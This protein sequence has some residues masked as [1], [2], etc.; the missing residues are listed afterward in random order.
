[1]AT[2]YTDTG[3]VFGVTYYY[4]LYT[5]DLAG[6]PAGTSVA[7]SA[8]VRT[9]DV[10]APTAL[11]SV[12]PRSTGVS[13]SPV[14][15]MTFS[16]PM[17]FG[18]TSTAITL[19]RLKDNL[20]RPL[21]QP[22]TVTVSSN[23]A[24]DVYTV[25]IAP[26]FLAGNSLYE[27]AIS[28]SAADVFGKT[29]TSSST[30]RFTTYLDHTVSNVVADGIGGAVVELS[31]GALAVDGYLDATAVSPSAVAAAT[32][33]LSG[34]TGDAFRSPLSSSVVDLQVRDVSGTLQPGT[35]SA[36]VSVT[37]PYADVDGDGIVDG[38]NPPAKAS[39]LGVYWLNARDDL[40]VRLPSSRDAAARQVSARSSHFTT[41]A[42]IPQADTD[43]SAAHPYPVP[44]TPRSGKTVVTFTSVG[45]APVIR[46]Y[47]LSGALVR[48]M[49]EPAQ[50]GQVDWDLK[51]ES[52]DP[53]AS[54]VYY[55][56]VSND[57]ERATGRLAVAR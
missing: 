42:L 55:Y 15:T 18:P 56:E 12:G 14:M 8:S 35:F 30:L 29:L 16:K 44:W 46:I 24:G 13:W 51:N 49:R 34:G 2:G 48:E 33:K 23:T 39:T 17:A 6:G 32:R 27:L 45:D 57:K 10:P 7:A 54:G 52:G 11:L 22:V 43:L 3:L 5:T 37:L 50:M 41:F 53:V 19:T 47:T 21:N 38:S 31:T 9:Q 20:A 4:N 40:W 1:L 26:S 25:S 36:P 28:T